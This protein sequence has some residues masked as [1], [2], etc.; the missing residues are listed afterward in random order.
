M[1]GQTAQTGAVNAKVYHLPSGPG[2]SA[3]LQPGFRTRSDKADRLDSLGRYGYMNIQADT[4]M[5][6]KTGRTDR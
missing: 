4:H 2:T 1:V 5:N 3:E 6:I